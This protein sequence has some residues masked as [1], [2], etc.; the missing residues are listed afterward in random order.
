VIRHA[1]LVSAIS[2]G[3]LS[4]EEVEATVFSGAAAPTERIYVLRREATDFYRLCIPS[5]GRSTG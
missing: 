1:A 5:S 2:G 3:A 4:V